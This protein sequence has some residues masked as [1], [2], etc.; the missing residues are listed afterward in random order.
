[1]ADILSLD[2]TAQLQALETRRISAVEL[3]DLAV[4][5]WRGQHARI[6]AV[7]AVDIDRARARARAI[8]D[9]RVQGEHL[10]V[11]A[12]LPMTIKDTLDVDGLPAS[13]GL[14]SL[15]RRSAVHDA[16]S[17]A[18]VRHEDA[19]IWGKTNVPVMAGDWQSF[20]GL[21]GASN[22]PWDLERTT[23]GS[24]GGAAAAL[25]TGVTA[26]EVGSDIGGSLRVP[27]AFCGVY[28]HKPTWGLVS[29]R[30]HVPP[31]PGTLAER[32]LNVIGPM[33]R[34]ARD[35]RLLLSVL[36]E[37]PLAAKAPPPPLKGLKIGLW[38]DEGSF[39]L[40]P[41][42]RAVIADFA[43]QLA[44]RGAAVEA[45]RPVDAVALMDAYR[46]LLM[47]TLEPDLPAK[48]RRSIRTTRGMADLARQLGAGAESWAAG[49]Q[50]YGASHAEWLAADE[51]RV[52]IGV[53]VKGL[54]ER[55]DVLLAPVTPVTAF[56]HNHRPFDRRRLV[57]SDGAR[58][59]Y[60]SMLN[61]IGLATACGLPA[62][63]I[64]AG[65]SPHGLPVGAQLIGPRGGDAR[66]LAVAQAI[67]D[68]LGGFLAP[69][70]L[71]AV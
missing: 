4:A 41:E 48:M 39:P 56:P 22:N 66:T 37:G 61:W 38:L 34:S 27:A 62:T 20:N 23:G 10:G 32:D 59:A 55:Y 5:R 36:E 68:E 54:F 1:V 57:Q 9:Q 13:A 25:A 6:N 2:A 28:S 45:V 42:V 50:R 8:D 52:R 15:R 7:V 69:P 65:L 70:P 16:A 24:S 12:G 47:S 43:V 63:A 49:V 67:E 26:L 60:T 44:G 40:D 58:I 35:L 46:V 30:G 31:A 3:L 19:V 33:A 21:Y 17:V 11:L 71:E 51:V 14:E 64:P 29:Q 18:R 53:Q